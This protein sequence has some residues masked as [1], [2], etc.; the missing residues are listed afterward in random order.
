MYMRKY[1]F[2]L[3]LFV[4]YLPLFAQDPS[5]SYTQYMNAL[6]KLIQE[7]LYS[8][9]SEVI[10][11]VEELP[12]KE[13]FI[14]F[15]K[16][17]EKDFDEIQAN[18][19][20]QLTDEEKEKGTQFTQTMMIQLGELYLDRAADLDTDAR[21]G[22]FRTFLLEMGYDQTLNSLNEDNSRA[23]IMGIHAALEIPFGMPNTEVMT[24]I[25]SEEAPILELYR[26]AYI[27]N[28][29]A[30]LNESYDAINAMTESF[31]T[32]YP[33][34]RFYESMKV[35]LISLE[36][37][38]EGAAVEDFSFLDMEGN[39]RSLSE[40]KD[41]IIYLDLWASWC[42]PCINTFKTKT[43]SFEKKLR[44]KEDVVLMYISIDENQEPWKKYLEK[45]PMRGVHLFAGKG[46]EA[47]IMRYFKV[48]GIPRYL[49]IGK[50]N[51]LI[52]PNAPRP[53][54]EAYNVLMEALGS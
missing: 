1:Y 3:L 14:D 20:S 33:D 10:Y 45:N 7:D 49:I 18:Y 32:A 29:M 11:D 47:E 44:E 48:W 52:S 38:R 34:S 13:V 28:E 31:K 25:Y 15:C 26:A 53:G 41:K 24:Y 8:R 39:P 12:T 27:M 36:K 54:D 9:V 5:A 16:G 6:Q 51:K 46:F 21:T 37:L 35:T 4:I 19:G 43:P 2:T 40:F 30:M 50:D 42:G 23:I 22:F 17:V